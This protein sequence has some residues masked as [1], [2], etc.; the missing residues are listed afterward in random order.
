[1]AYMDKQWAECEAIRRWGVGAWVS[2]ASGSCQVGVG[3]IVAGD[4]ISWEEA[5]ARADTS[6]HMRGYLKICER[7]DQVKYRLEVA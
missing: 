6:P 5:F 2:T 4:G 7:L 3:A 1:M